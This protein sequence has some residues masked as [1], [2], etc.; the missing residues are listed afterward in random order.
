MKKPNR[1]LLDAFLQWYENDPHAK[2]E[3][4]YA[5]KVTIENLNE[6]SRSYNQVLETAT[7]K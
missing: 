7:V 6:L 1:E 3:D 5:E 2:N 4:H